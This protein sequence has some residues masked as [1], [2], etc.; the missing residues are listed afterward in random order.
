MP[1]RHR[2]NYSPHRPVSADR[3]LVPF[4][5]VEEAWFWFIRANEARNA[6]ARFTAGMGDVPRPCEPLDILR[7][8]DRLYRN[9][10]LLWDHMLVLKHY[11][12]RRL[13]PDPDRIKEVRACTLWQEALA[14]LEP[15]MVR[16]GIV[17]Q[18]QE[19][20]FGRAGTC[21]DAEVI[22]FPEAAE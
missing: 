4:S 13:P 8:L 5:S 16:K 3:D 6:G 15:I 7:I 9:R 18:S 1:G 22:P 19:C 2:P 10:R 12:L 14:R 20:L 21:R 17:R 11:G